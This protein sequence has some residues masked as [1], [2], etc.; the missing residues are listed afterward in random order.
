VSLSSTVIAEL[1]THRARQAEEQLRL[2]LRPDG[3]SFVVAQVDGS[4]IQPRSL[5]HEWVRIIRQDLPAPH[6]L[7]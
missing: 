5:T 7:P 4:P 1:K 2:G 3:D 6:P